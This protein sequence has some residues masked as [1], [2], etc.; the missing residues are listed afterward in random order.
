MKTKILV[1]LMALFLISSSLFA[2]NEVEFSCDD[3]LACVNDKDFYAIVKRVVRRGDIVTIQLEYTSKQHARY[4][5]FTYGKEFEGYALIID[6]QGQ[7]F[8]VEGKNISDFKLGKGEKKVMSLRFAGDQK[9]KIHEPFDL[10]I[11][12]L[13][14]HGEIT[15]FD[16][17]TEKRSI[18]VQE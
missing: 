15:F 9:K 5:R 18:A 13:E 1:C 10:T 2:K 4:F 11:K 14:P 6:A 16:L 8:K 17:G 3:K 12:A 7:E